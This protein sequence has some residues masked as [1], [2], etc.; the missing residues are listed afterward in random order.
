MKT[1]LLSL[2]LSVSFCY[3]R[4]QNIQKQAGKNNSVKNNI[5]Q[6][7]SIAY[8]NPFNEYFTIENFN[9]AKQIQILNAMGKVVK[10]IEVVSEKEIIETYDLN[11]GLYLVLVKY[12]NSIR[13]S[14]PMIK[15]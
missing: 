9:G 13:K 1:S 11:T 2:L 8:P 14:A 10:E 12:D 5:N 6:E 3:L 4:A 7:C 15:H